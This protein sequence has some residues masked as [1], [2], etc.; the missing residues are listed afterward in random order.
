MIAPESW[1]GETVVSQ[2]GSGVPATVARYLLDELSAA[3]PSFIEDFPEPKQ[4]QK[5]PV[6]SLSGMGV[7]E[8]CPSVTEEYVSVAVA[9]QTGLD[10]KGLER[11]S[12]HYSAED[13]FSGRGT[14]SFK[15]TSVRYPQEYQRWLQ[16]QVTPSQFFPTARLHILYPQPG[17]VF[18]YDTSIPSS[19]QKIRIDATG[20]G[21]Q[22]ELFVNG[23]SAGVSTSP[24]SWFV[25]LEPGTMQL[26]VVLEDGQQ[27]SQEVYVR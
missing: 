10:G 18:L 20:S 11:C 17:A 14:S 24:F 12:W 21:S 1:A 15:V 6:C 4:F 8:F 19:A 25:P 13:L 9:A 2:T 27:V 3:N 5:V 22:A 26:K 16:G 23:R 7:T